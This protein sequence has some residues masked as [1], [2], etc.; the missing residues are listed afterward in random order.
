MTLVIV[1][2]AVILASSRLGLAQAPTP[3]TASEVLA[4]SL[5]DMR[6]ISESFENPPP[7]S[8]WADRKGLLLSIFGSTTAPAQPVRAGAAS[9]AVSAKRLRHKVPKEAGKAYDKGIKMKDLQKGARELERAIALDPEFGVAHCGLGVN[10]AR[11]GLFSQAAAQFRRAIELLPE[12][13]IPY[14]NLAWLLFLTGQ[15]DEALTNIR[16]ALRLSPDNLP[17]RMLA[18]QMKEGVR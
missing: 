4:S 10:Y 2:A 13:S 18:G 11:L 15:R 6:G 5:A 8:S 16:Q 12:E 3:Q 14:S 17:A 7:D 9:G 1:R